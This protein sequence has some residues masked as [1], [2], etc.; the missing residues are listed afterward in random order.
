MKIDVRSV[1]YSDLKE[2]PEWIKPILTSINR[3]ID[4]SKFI[5]NG[6]IEFVENIKCIYKDFEVTAPVQSYKVDIDLKTKIKE[7]RLIHFN[8]LGSALH[9]TGQVMTWRQVSNG[10]IIDSISGMSAGLK[11]SVQIMVI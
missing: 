7:V 1:L 10:L 5:L 6:N 9:T 4:Q 8:E 2:N 11:Y 3:L